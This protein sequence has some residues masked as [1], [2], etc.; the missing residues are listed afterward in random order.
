MSTASP[1]HS[2]IPDVVTDA[3]GEKL[4]RAA[5]IGSGAPVLAFDVGGT[6]IKS[7]LF[8][9]EGAAVGL[10]RTP[11]PV[12]G[13]G[14]AERLIDRLA[15]LAAELRA[16]HPDIVPQAV[17]LVVPGIV[18]EQAGVGVFSSNLGWRNAPMRDLAQAR[19]GL[20]VAFDHDVRAASWAEHVLGGAR[21]YKNSVVLIIGTGIAGAI[22]IDGRPHTAGGYAGEIGHSP[23]GEWP[24]PCG[25]R[26]CLEAVA[27]AGAISRR[28]AEASGVGAGG[29]KEVIALAASGDETAARIWNEALDALTLSIAQLTAVIAPEAVVIGGGLSRAGGA[30]FDE[31]RTR[32]QDRLSFHRIPELVPA[33]LS[34][35]A[36]ILGSA[37]HAREAAS[38]AVSGGGA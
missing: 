6:D 20:P 30:L 26:G 10:R 18:D 4:A 21:S 3:S 8:D 14:G 13:E 32:L 36:G 11:T 5:S 9:A 7:A 17:G 22:L 28:Y 19:F 2:S 27:S 24:C 35:N 33:E 23:I 1:D 34:G 16:Q 15:D 12:G 25:A 31:L 38:A 29:A 37:L